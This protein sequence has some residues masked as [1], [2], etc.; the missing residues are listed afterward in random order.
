MLAAGLFLPL[1]AAALPWITASLAVVGTGVAV[2]GYLDQQK[3]GEASAKASAEIEAA[4]RR[5]EELRKQQLLLETRRRQRDAIRQGI[6]AKARAVSNATQQGAGQSSGL[7]GGLAQ[8]SGVVG[9]NVL[10]TSENAQIGL[11]IFDAN[12]DRASA[13]SRLGIARTDA[14]TGAGLYSLGTSLVSAAPT[15]SSV[16]ASLVSRTGSAIGPWTTSV[17]TP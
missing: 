4:S 11:G 9:Q 7:E 3:A 6:I 16:G 5:A 13:E 1:L 12:A 8:I 15:I 17:S 2:K 14:Q 10:G